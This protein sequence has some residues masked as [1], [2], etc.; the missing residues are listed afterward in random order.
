[1]RNFKELAA[2][3]R[4]T[5]K[6]EVRFDDGS[7]AL[8]ATDSSNYRQV[9]I[10]VV[11]PKNKNDVI[12]TVALCRK[13]GASV[14]CRGAGTSLA[15]QGCNAAVVI[16]MSKFMNRILDLD[17]QKQT[18]RVQPGVV[19]DTLRRAA[20]KKG[21]TF[22]PDPATHS[23]CTLGGMLGNNSCGVHALMAGKTVDNVISMEILT[24]DGLI[25]EVGETSEAELTEKISRG[26]RA[27]EIYSRLRSIRDRYADLVRQRYPKIPRRVSGYNLDELLPENGFNIA[28][29]LV[30]SEGTCATILE[31]TLRLVRWPAKQTL[32][33]LGYPDIYQAG[34]HIPEIL[35]FK[36]LGLEAVDYQLVTFLRKQHD[37]LE[38]IQLLPPGK[39]WLLVEFGGETKEE[40][41]AKARQMISALGTR[42]QAPA[43][44][45][46][47]DE[48]EAAT[49][50]KIRE[51]ALAATAFVPGRP[52]TF[53]GW[54]D[55]AVRPD[56]AGAYL[57]E[58][59]ALYEK[60]GYEGAFYGHFGQ[61]CIHTRIT[62]DFSSREGLT[63][64]RKFLD[65]AS[66]LVLKYGG[67][68]SG[69]HGDGQARAEL[70][71][72]MFGP[73]LMEAFREFKTAWDPDRK[74][75]PGKL[76]DAYGILENMRLE[77]WH[78]QAPLTHFSFDDVGGTFL[79]AALRCVGVG[80]CRK[81][82]S[83]VMCP[84]YMATLEEKYS[85]RGRSRMLFEMLQ[86]E[87]IKGGW[88]DKSVKEA[89]DLCLSCKGCKGECP[90]NVDMA[91]YKSEFFSHYYEGRLRPIRAYAFG[92]IAWWSRMASA[93]PGLAN[94]IGQN[95]VTGRLL[96]QLIGIAPEREI[97][98]F[99]EQTFKQWFFGRGDNHLPLPSGERDGGEGP[100][101][102]PSSNPSPQK[103]EGT[104]SYQP[105]ILWADTFNNHFHPEVARAAVEVLEQ[106][107]FNVIVPR[108]LF[109]CGRPLY[110]HG[111]LKLAKQWL[112]N[113]MDYL[114][115]QIRQGI[116]MVVLEPSCASVF[117]D[118][119]LNFFP[120]DPDA[121]RLSSQTFLLSEFLEMVPGYKPPILK[122]KAVVHGHCHHKALMKMADE[123]AILR[124][125]Q[126][127]F[128]VPE[129]GCC[130]MA[131]AFGFEK[132]HSAVAG[133]IGERAL[134]P[135]V[136]ET[137]EDTLIIADGFSCREQ[138][139]QGTGR[140]ALH[141]AQVLRLI[142]NKPE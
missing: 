121:L 136:R 138:I 111:M 33:V 132:E 137:P 45:L 10:G 122:R 131:G 77:N 12:Q 139:R 38:N 8:Y 65:E 100:F 13:Y 123:E 119:L 22:G 87:V 85:T 141:L 64:F 103:G 114:R 102:K 124:K 71:P 29:A 28:R 129:S 31:A 105:V 92:L 48:K 66:D 49:V 96:K 35:S 11:I 113:I 140:K 53:E 18:T 109:C 16:D 59:R 32:V 20:E 128:S 17:A 98:R 115:P 55:S 23:H 60:Y 15:G 79:R 39:G 30:G 21:L 127:D 107:G 50:W 37:R 36:P 90:V 24:Y 95:A 43:A 27:G 74:M 82:D 94:F 73:E 56:Q 117:R 51:G 81:T 80:K 61:G 134:L 99:A 47:S 76:I 34:D 72:K 125:M 46:F 14:L 108:G 86:G 26:G 52:D 9:P 69:E 97:P 1:M 104:R 44:K 84:S 57:R 130:G 120:H 93:V 2:A 40:S 133:T 101:S 116:P 41:D 63:T 19:L 3:L 78:P 5:I 135:A 25:I 126:V 4:R 70:L 106:A 88:K 89:L 62:F 68:F 67:S 75:N 7:R 110:E 142:K 42:S 112:I 91:S 83:G 54:E 58:L 118:E 6:G